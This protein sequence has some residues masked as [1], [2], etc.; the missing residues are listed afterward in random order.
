MEVLANLWHSL[1]SFRGRGSSCRAAD[2]FASANLEWMDFGSKRKLIKDDTRFNLL[3]NQLVLIAPKDSKLDSV[4]IGPNLDVAKLAGDGSIAVGDVRQV[5]VGKYAK[6][7]LEKLGAWQA[8]APKLAKASN[9]RVA[10]NIVARGEAS[11][12]IVYTTD[13]NVARY[14]DDR[15]P[16]CVENL[17]VLRPGPSATAEVSPSVKIIRTFPADA[18]PAIAYPVAATVTAKPEAVDYLAFL[19]SI[20][21][22]A[23]FERYGFTFLI[24]PTS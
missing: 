17:N 10:L 23:I 20:T 13:A 15:R 9:V 24:Q 21:A 3:G 4:A 12:G 19:R 18:H 16:H 8:A 22:K 11:L 7:A 2:V 14:C 6:A 5:P 1:P